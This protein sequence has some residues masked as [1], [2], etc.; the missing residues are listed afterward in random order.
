MQYWIHEGNLHWHRG[1]VATYPFMQ[2]R[3]VEERFPGFSYQGVAEV[4][5]LRSTQAV[6][7]DVPVGEG[8]LRFEGEGGGVVHLPTLP[9]NVDIR[10]FIRVKDGKWR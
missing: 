9:D 4:E 5:E 2:R 8:V 6:N 7:F 1:A 3:G 10:G